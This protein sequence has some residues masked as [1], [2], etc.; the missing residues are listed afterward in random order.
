MSRFFIIL[1]VLSFLG[2][3]SCCKKHLAIGL[4]IEYRNLSGDH[5]LSVIKQ[6]KDDPG[7]LETINVIPLNE[8]HLHTVF[9]E[10][11][12]LSNFNIILQV[13]STLRSD[14]IRD[15]TY[16]VKG[17]NCNSRVDNVSYTLNRDYRT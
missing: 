3:N 16:E 8:N 4:S 14:T 5:E 13:D 6:S 12:G 17:N 1:A 10:L 7:F 15:F 9:V 11:E 2:M